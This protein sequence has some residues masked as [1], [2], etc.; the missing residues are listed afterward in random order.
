MITV[1]A[2]AGPAVGLGHLSRAGAV[3]AALRAQGHEV[4]TYVLG[5]EAVDRD[6]IAWAA[7]EDR[8]APPPG[9]GPLLVD[10]YRVDV[11]ALA[12]QRPVATF[13]DGV[14]PRPARA[15]L[16][17]AFTDPD[18]PRLACLRPMFWG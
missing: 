11:D 6:G 18:G 16:T 2:D 3:V 1:L 9:D 5:G 8:V 13:F 12:A 4:D 7:L 10:S 15:A 14:G 17:I